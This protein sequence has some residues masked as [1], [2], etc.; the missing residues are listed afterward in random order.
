MTLVAGI[1][2]GG[3]KTAAG[4]VDPHGTLRRRHTVPTPASDG[5][6]AVVAA[7]VRAVRDLGVPVA[8]VGVGS[9]GVVDPESGRIVSATDALPGW[10]GTALRRD[11]ERALGVP[12]AVDNDVHAHA[13]GEAWRGAAAGR[14]HVLL[15]AVGTGIGG[16]LLVDGR[17]HHGARSAAGHAGH[18][19]VPSAA[20]APCTCGGTSHAEAV[21]SG[22]ALLA[23]YARSAPVPAS[24][25]A[26]VSARADG[27]E[28]TAR[29]VLA[30]GARALGE[31][32]GGIVNMTDPE[33][34]LVGGG[35]AHCGPAW[36]EPLRQAFEAELLPPLKGV[37]LRPGSLGGD[38]ALLGA[39]RL[40][41]E[42]L[43]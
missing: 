6:A 10:A 43:R 11:L 41:L 32:L 5:P 36:W 18:V 1:D 14:R 13:L 28:E 34:V 35:V 42:V 8:A 27:G 29:R 38:A 7:A 2:I 9:A 25:L 40:A 15:A 31:A 12:V 20:G 24:S 37:E 16:S 33:L 22:P 19:P 39:A 21:G 26:E 4:I 3:T 30:R 23:A 17:V